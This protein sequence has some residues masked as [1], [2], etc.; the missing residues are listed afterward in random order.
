MMTAL[1]LAMSL[2]QMQVSCLHR[3]PKQTHLPEAVSQRAMGGVVHREDRKGPE[4]SPQN[5][6]PFITPVKIVAFFQGKKCCI[7]ETELGNGLR[8][9]SKSQK[10]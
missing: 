1:D 5:G 7:G 4:A 9:R 8:R 3:L 6:D 2:W 10:V